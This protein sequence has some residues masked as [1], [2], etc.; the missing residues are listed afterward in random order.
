MKNNQRPQR[1]AQISQ[2]TRMAPAVFETILFLWLQ[3]GVLLTLP[4]DGG[5]WFSTDT[6]SWKAILIN[7]AIFAVVLYLLNGRSKRKSEGFQ[8]AAATVDQEKL[9][10]RT[11]SSNKRRI[12][13]RLAEAQYFGAL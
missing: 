2:H 13:E 4:P 7:A 9:K 12:Q 3:P 11:A 10:E 6:T 1:L 8:D 5:K